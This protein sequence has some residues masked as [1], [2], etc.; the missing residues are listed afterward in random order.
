ML[1]EVDAR[2]AGLGRIELL[3]NVARKELQDGR[4]ARDSETGAGCSGLL[5]DTGF[6]V[7]HFQETVTNERTTVRPAFGVDFLRGWVSHYDVVSRPAD[8]W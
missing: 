3:A 5:L 4:G 7:G 2:V 8:C 6:R 1:E